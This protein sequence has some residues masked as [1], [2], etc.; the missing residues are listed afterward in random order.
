MILLLVVIYITFIGLGIPDSLFGTAW[1]A[2][3]EEMG[4]PM[5]FASIVT[6]TISAC[7][8]IS[9]LFSARLINKFGTG[10]VTVVSTVFTVVGLLGF[11]LSYSFIWLCLCALPLGLGAGAI[12]TALNNFVS[13]HYKASH[14]SFLHCFYGVGVSL[15][16]YL[17]SFALADNA[18]WRHGY[19]VMFIVQSVIAVI[20][21][22]SLPLWKK[23]G[24]NNSAE[25]TEVRTLK[26]KE[27]VKMKSVRSISLLFVCACAIEYTC[28]I[29]GSTYLVNSRA[30]TVDKAAL[31]VTLYY[32]GMAVGRF[33]SGV[34]SHKLS[35]YNIIRIG[36]CI[37]VIAVIM[38]MLPF[39]AEVSGVFLLMI[40]LG[41]SVI[42]PN[43]TFL[44][45]QIFGR[46]ISQSVMGTQMAA[47]Y[48]G[49]MLLPPIFGLLAQNIT[50][51]IFPYFIIVLFVI[52]IFAQFKL[53]HKQK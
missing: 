16:P 11:S 42:Y 52:M 12:D 28:G 36:E 32:V 24:N 46:D 49:T 48:V 45:P 8:I 13:V 33:L 30:M 1:P 14:M 41:N 43:L 18:D 3:Y 27:L 21:I 44:T 15:S 23:A 39:P 9:S 2:I 17:M 6:L 10:L 19:F 7:T 35:P 47:S 38:L 20:T 40:G 34:F 25:E 50:T 5:S 53:F 37:E 31:F 26:L 51:D 22:V 29:W 4:V